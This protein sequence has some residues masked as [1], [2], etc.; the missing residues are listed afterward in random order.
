M[1]KARRNSKQRVKLR[2][3]LGNRTD[4]PDA[5]TIYKE[6]RE[7]YPSISLCTVYRNLMLLAD[8]KELQII[9]AGDGKVHFDPNPVP[10]AHFFCNCCH[11][12]TDFSTN[13]QMNALIHEQKKKFNGKIEECE[14]IF[15]GICADCL[16]KIS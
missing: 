6:I 10:H 15:K 12:V 9:N 7:I 16:N 4:H 3:I 11:K 5:Q 2:E 13:E 1:E 8:N 14:V